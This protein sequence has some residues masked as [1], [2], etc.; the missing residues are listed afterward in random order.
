LKRGRVETLDVSIAD[1]GQRH[2]ANPERQQVRV[3]VVI[4]VHVANREIVSC[5]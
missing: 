4:F 1:D 3:G 5:A 2:G